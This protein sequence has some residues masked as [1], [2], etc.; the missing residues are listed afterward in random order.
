MRHP[1]IEAVTFIYNVKKGLRLPDQ[2]SVHTAEQCV[3]TQRTLSQM[4]KCYAV[5]RNSFHHFKRRKTKNETKCYWLHRKFIKLLQSGLP[6]GEEGTRKQMKELKRQLQ[7]KQFGF[8]STGMPRPHEVMQMWHTAWENE[9]KGRSYYLIQSS[10]PLNCADL[11]KITRMRLGYCELRR[12][13]APIDKHP[14]WK[15]ECEELESVGH[16]WF[17]FEKQS[18]NKHCR[19]MSICQNSEK[20]LICWMIACSE[21]EQKL[22]EQKWWSPNKGQ[23]YSAAAFS[24]PEQMKKKK[25]MKRMKRKSNVGM[26]S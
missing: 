13:L 11:A 15:C 22:L 7:A 16:A 10:G 23:K 18:P 17:W 5:S 4:K 8:H 9:K 3:G 24:L 19:C 20:F 2:I 12:G 26:L 14:D 1:F 21:F 25:R 6:V